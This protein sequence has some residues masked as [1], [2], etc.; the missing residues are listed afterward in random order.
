VLWWDQSQDLCGTDW[1]LCGRFSLRYYGV[2]L[3]AF[4]MVGR[5]SVVGCH[6]LFWLQKL[7]FE[8]EVKRAFSKTAQFVIE[9]YH[10]C[11]TITISYG[12]VTPASQDEPRHGFSSFSQ[13]M[14]PESSSSPWHSSSAKAPP[15]MVNTF[16]A[17]SLS[18]LPPP[19]HN[20]SRK[21]LDTDCRSD[22]WHLLALTITT[23]TLI[24]SVASSFS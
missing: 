3:C 7:W 2:A 19:L 8:H 22:K 5:L 16:A 1:K 10:S 12:P 14:M 6:C 17:P 20:S 24:L 4:V 15:S 23:R 18:V 13:S 11:R 21:R 9:W